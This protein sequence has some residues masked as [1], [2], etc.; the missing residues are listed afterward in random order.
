MGNLSK[1]FKDYEKIRQNFDR[2]DPIFGALR[3]GG[4]GPA[5]HNRR[6]A[7]VPEW[8]M[9][10]AA[11][12]AVLLRA[13]PKWNTNPTQHERAGRWARIIDLYFRA[14]HTAL[15]VAMI[16]RHDDAEKSARTAQGR[17]ATNAKLRLMSEKK[18][19]EVLTKRVTDTVAR[20][21]LLARGL[22]T[23]SKLRNGKMGR[24]RKYNGSSS[25]L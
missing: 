15:H 19:T 11:V 23:D 13:F 10:D 6:V 14:G 5:G 24:P 8:V 25:T 20:I 17:D 18:E 7:N 2:N 4:N 21:L 16:L 3:T 22:R 9:N 1:K 12:R